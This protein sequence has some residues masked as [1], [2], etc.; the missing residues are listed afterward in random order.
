LQTTTCGFGYLALQAL[1][2]QHIGEA[3]SNMKLSKERAVAVKKFIAA[4]GVESSRIE[5]KNFGESQPIEN[6]NDEKGRKANR[7]VEIRFIQ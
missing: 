6:N 2:G 4:S 1:L 7:R 5:I 3:D